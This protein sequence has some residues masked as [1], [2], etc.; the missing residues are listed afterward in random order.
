M[1]LY[2]VKYKYKNDIFWKIIK[3]VKGDGFIISEHGFHYDVRYFILN[4]ESRIEVSTKNCI[5]KFSKERYMSIVERME[6]DA[7]QKVPID[8]K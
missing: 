7:K 1:M 2:T 6:I 4:D 8:P 5:F 3:N